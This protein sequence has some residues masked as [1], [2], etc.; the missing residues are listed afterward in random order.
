MK[1]CKANGVELL[2]VLGDYG[3]GW[4]SYINGDGNCGVTEETSLLAEKYGL[5][6]WFID[7]NHENFDQLE[8]VG[9]YGSIV[10]V[11]VE[12]NVTYIP[13]G[14]LLKLGDSQ[15][16]F[17]GGA[18]SVDKGRRSPHISW[19]PEEEI[20]TAETN[21]ALS[22]EKVDVVLSHDVCDTGF[23]AA[24]SLALFPGETNRHPDAMNH[25][26]YKNDQHFPHARFNRHTLEAIWEHY[27]PKRW[28]HGHYHAS[29]QAR[30]HGTFFN[31]LA[32]N[33]HPGAFEIVEF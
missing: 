9:A 1:I 20:T 3:Y 30:E 27:H 21:R 26:V 15:V 11:K 5:Q 4:P 25:L 6:V 12:E 19:W 10:P 22:H 18:Y 8:A 14:T 24:L 28:Y 13:R 23:R 7:G 31:G 2:I 17:V 16:L 32:N 29:Y 33:T